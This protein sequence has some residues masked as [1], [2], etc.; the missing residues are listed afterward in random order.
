MI[1]LIISSND[2]NE[3]DLVV[4]EE[5]DPSH[6]FHDR[7]GHSDVGIHMPENH[8]HEDIQLSHSNK[9]I[10]VTYIMNLKIIFS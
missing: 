2:E 3:D 9:D 8:F 1:I 6:T 10:L 4:K 5:Y 7:H